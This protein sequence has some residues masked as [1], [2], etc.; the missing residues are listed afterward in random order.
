MYEFCLHSKG[1]NYLILTKTMVIK[2]MCQLS[3]KKRGSLSAIKNL[4]SLVNS[5][6]KKND[7]MI[8]MYFVFKSYQNLEEIVVIKISD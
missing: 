6:E 8:N 3:F 2:I 5:A 4:H 7:I 1:C